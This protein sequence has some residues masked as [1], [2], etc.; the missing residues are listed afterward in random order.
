M[1]RSSI[2]PSLSSTQS[3]SLPVPFCFCGW[4][5]FHSMCLP[6]LY[7]HNGPKYTHQRDASSISTT[8]FQTFPSCP[9]SKPTSQKAVTSP[10]SLLPA[11]GTHTSA[12]CLHRFRNS[13][14]FAWTRSH[15]LCP[16]VV[17]YPMLWFQGRVRESSLHS[18]FQPYPVLRMEPILCVH[19][20]VDGHLDHFCCLLL[21]IGIPWS[22]VHT[23]LWKHL[24]TISSLYTQ[25]GSC[26]VLLYWVLLVMFLFLFFI[27]THL[28]V[29]S[30][31]IR[32]HEI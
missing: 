5:T 24:L 23:C 31:G 20:S 10:A 9:A 29:I 18:A 16:S 15:P 13:G 8:S 26:W 22:S 2:C 28:N 21:S 27:S 30:R 1:R 12:L 14:P 4:I 19:L 3:W 7:L 17:L 32:K 11:S 25:D 6:R